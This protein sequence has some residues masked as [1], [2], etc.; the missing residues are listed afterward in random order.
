MIRID[1]I[2]TM[3]PS[4]VWT[5]KNAFFFNDPFGINIIATASSDLVDERLRYDIVWQ[6]VNP[7]DDP[8]NTRWFSFT[9][10]TIIGYHTID[11]HVRNE[12]FQW[13]S[14]GHWVT[15]GQYSDA[16]SHVSGVGSNSGVF[17]VRGSIEVQ[18]TDQ[19]DLTLPFAFNYKV[20]S[21]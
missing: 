4:D 1:R 20:R 11:W 14:F 3:D 5:P 19:F 9:G 16:V 8:Y 18:G 13:P 10:G 2:F 21:N 6:M 15:W 17:S 12:V 7:R